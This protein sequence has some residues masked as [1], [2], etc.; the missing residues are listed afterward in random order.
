MVFII[1]AGIVAFIYL[2]FAYYP[3]FGGKATKGKR[4]Q[5]NQS[6]NFSKNKF[7]NLIPT[8]TGINN[9]DEGLFSTLKEL[10]VGNPNRRPKKEIPIER[11]NLSLL[12]QKPSQDKLIWFG[13][14]AFYLE[15]EGKS[16]LIDPMLGRAPSPF[17][18]IGKGRYNKELP[19]HIEE[20]PA[21][22]IVLIS[23][24]H[25]DHL[26]Y[27]TIK[28][29]RGKVKQFIVPLGV[30]K[31]LERWGICPSIIMELD[32]WDEFQ[33]K[34]LHFICTPSRHFSGRSLTDRNSTL[35]CSW[36]MRGEKSSLFY[37]GDSGYGPHFKEIGQKYGPFDLTLME[38][39]QYDKRWAGIH[40]VPEETVKAHLDLRGVRMIPI[41]WGAFTLSFHDWNEPID[42]VTKAAREKQVTIATPK[43]GEMVILDAK[44]LPYT[45]W[46]RD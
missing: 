23:H 3:P 43:I 25:Y 40:M 42:R 15:I 11:V 34:G 7:A 19:L 41:H 21:I 45:T 18:L 22:D 31:H 9:E 13:H 1:L 10:L 2:F 39:G 37:S 44:D 4:N 36:V 5:L 30:A 6:V 12:H 32:W 26:D 29:I 20:L 27:G 14:S 28:K 8:P 35:W 17:P 46:W 33:F 24:D 16:I 38:C